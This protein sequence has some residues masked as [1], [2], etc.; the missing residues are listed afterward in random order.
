[1]SKITLAAAVA[2]TATAVGISA[3]SASVCFDPAS[4][5]TAGTEI[6]V[7]I[8]DGKNST[9]G[10][11]TAGTTTVDYSSSD[12]LDFANG[13]A[14]ITPSSKGK[15]SSYSD[16]T[17]TTPGFTFTDFEF[18]AEMV[19]NKDLSSF[20]FTISAYDGSTLL[21]SEPVTL[22]HDQLTGFLITSTTPMTEIIL[23]DSTGFKET[24]LFDFSG[25][26]KITSGPPPGTPLP[27]ALPLFATGLGALGFFS[28]RRKRKAQAGA[29]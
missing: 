16:L 19:N 26:S 18:S 20:G 11:G 1:M 28:R 12:F 29:A 4:T 13:N 8:T 2:A 15:A 9:T 17:I 25:L 7:N 22:K 6:S 10:S 27:A 21:G 3:A 24:K 5:C 14:T 23:N